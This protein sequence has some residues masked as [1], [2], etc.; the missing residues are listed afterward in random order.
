VPAAR[1]QL[2]AEY[3]VPA[4]ADGMLPWDFVDERMRAAPNY[5]VATV[6]PGGTP[7]ARPVDGV[8]VDGALCFG[9]SPKT[10]WVRNLL[11]NPKIS[12]NVPGADD[13]VILEGVAEIVTD[14]AHELVAP[15]SEA[16]RAKYPQYYGEDTPFRPFWMVRPAVVYA[17]SLSGFPG[18]VTRWRMD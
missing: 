2:P 9:G 13:V 7:H 3:G 18:N 10:R 6:G 12:V 14:S 1:P 16:Q 17:W 5:W 4:E 8:W 15:S 11:D